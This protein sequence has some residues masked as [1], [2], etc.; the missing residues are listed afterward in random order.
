LIE[1][2]A[3]VAGPNIAKGRAIL[4]HLG[5]GASLAAVRGGQSIETNL[6]NLAFWVRAADNGTCA[7]LSDP[8]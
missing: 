5:P 1:E 8:S 7:G 3:R 6:A 2:V 4:A